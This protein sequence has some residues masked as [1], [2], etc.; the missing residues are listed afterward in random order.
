MNNNEFSKKPVKYISF[1]EMNDILKYIK[2]N[3]SVYLHK[4]RDDESFLPSKCWIDVEPR[5][6][7]V[8]Y[9][10]D[11]GKA[12]H[13]AFDLAEGNTHNKINPGV[14][15]ATLGK[16]YKIPEIRELY[17]EIAY[18]CQPADCIDEKGRSGMKVE[19]LLMFNRKFEYK[20]T[21]AYCYD[22][23]SAY[24]WAMLQDMPD[25]SHG[26]RVNDVVGDN[27]IGFYRYKG[28]NINGDITSSYILVQPGNYAH[29]IFPR[30]K[31]PFGR[32]VDTWYNKKVNAKDAEE[33]LK[34]KEML[35]YCIGCLQNHNP[36]IRC[37]IV[38]YCNNRIIDII[39]KE[40]KKGNDF[41][42]ANTDC[43]TLTKPIDYLQIGNDVGE[44]KLK[45]GYFAFRGCNYQWDLDIPTYRGVPKKWFPEGWD[46]LK[47]P[48]PKSNNNYV[49]DAER[50]EIIINEIN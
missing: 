36:F 7:T 10:D 45:E 47:C 42:Y 17:P 39:A 20:R 31:S 37:A 49:F 11:T 34:A 35:N 29:F 13:Y 33:K 19:P 46:I 23:N 43:V 30:M 3:K 9:K 6:M 25:T 41:L 5:N 32:F 21:Y 22:M 24:S 28:E 8:L 44:W 50:M 2:L 27:E 12:R 16:Y 18:L 40:R 26:L 14:A 15:I 1:T 4:K 38:N 48:L